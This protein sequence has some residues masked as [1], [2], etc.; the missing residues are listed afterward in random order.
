M[1][2][3]PSVYTPS[4]HISKPWISIK[5]IEKLIIHKVPFQAKCA[6]PIRDS[7]VQIEE[8]EEE[9]EVTG[10]SPLMQER[11]KRARDTR[12]NMVDGIVVPKKKAKAKPAAKA[13][14]GNGSSSSKD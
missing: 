2:T 6:P 4:G 5:L 3:I 13:H 14:E 8:V 7:T 10:M 12:D 11:M 9:E 1:Y